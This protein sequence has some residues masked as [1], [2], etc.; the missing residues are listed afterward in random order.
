MARVAIVMNQ[1]IMSGSGP[2][3]TQSQGAGG[4]VIGGASVLRD[5]RP[6]IRVILSEFANAQLLGSYIAT[7]RDS[8]GSLTASQ[9]AVERHSV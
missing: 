5:A 4:T 6:D 9:P 2:E 8:N 3:S 7:K 1:L